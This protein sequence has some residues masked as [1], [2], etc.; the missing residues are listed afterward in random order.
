MTSTLSRDHQQLVYMMFA[1]EVGPLLMQKYPN[2]EKM[3]FNQILGRIW[4]ELPQVE[5][6]KYIIK[7]DLQ[8]NRDMGAPV[9]ISPAVPA[10]PDILRQ[11]INST[12][13]GQPPMVGRPPMAMVGQPRMVG[14]PQMVGRP[15][16]MSSRPPVAPVPMM[17]PFDMYAAQAKMILVRKYPNLG[18]REIEQHV[19]RMWT[20]LSQADKARFTDACMRQQQQQQQ[21]QQG[22]RFTTNNLAQAQQQGYMTN[23]FTQAQQQ[24]PRFLINN[25]VQA[26]QVGPTF[27]IN[28]FSQGPR[29][30]TPG[31]AP[32]MMAMRQVPPPVQQHLQTPNVTRQM[33]TPSSV[34]PLPLEQLNKVKV[35]VTEKTENNFMREEDS[36]DDEDDG[37]ETLGEGCDMPIL[38]EACDIKKLPLAVV[39][40]DQVDL[41]A[42]ST[43][44]E[45]KVE[46][47]TNDEVETDPLNLEFKISSTQEA[48]ED[49]DPDD[50]EGVDMPEE[51]DLPSDEDPDESDEGEKQTN[52]LDE[53][54]SPLS[55]EENKS[56]KYKVPPVDN[57]SPPLKS[58]KVEEK[59]GQKVVLNN[60]EK[61][62][63][64]CNTCKVLVDEVKKRGEL[65]EKL[66]QK[67]KLMEAAAEK[68]S[69]SLNKDGLE[70]DG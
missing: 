59:P 49:E 67:I 23:N 39:S 38:S 53:L 56:H 37:E 44:K 55:T 41:E 63:Q 51:D 21:Q 48:D 30:Q 6:N 35:N 4:G 32:Q 20:Q 42:D 60:P 36:E 43:T 24:G 70:V 18:S 40:T 69:P 26:Q 7:A 61:S 64:K 10:R 12:L 1:R 22:P 57:L 3:Q 46:D 8:R 28:T 11:A 29:L 50:P 65:I 17:T 47:N 52:P 2:I 68:K 19:L 54:S 34:A 33:T 5:K 13:L 45:Q 16:M 14:Q 31:Q 25:S 62:T 15:P 58:I 9:P 27:T 66:Q